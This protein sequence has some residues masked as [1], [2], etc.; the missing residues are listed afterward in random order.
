MNC[1]TASNSTASQGFDISGSANLTA[2]GAYVVSNT[3]YTGNAT[4]VSIPQINTSQS[5]TAD[6]YASRSIPSYGG[7]DKT[8]Y[9]PGASTT[10]SPN[11]GGIYVLC[12]GLTINAGVT[13]NL[14]PGTYIIDGGVLKITGGGGLIG[15]NVTL[16]LTG[17]T[18]GQSCCA[19]TNVS[20]G[21]VVQLTA[22][23]TGALSGL[24]IFQ[25][26]NAPSGTGSTMTGGDT[27]LISGA[28]YFPNTTLTYTGNS[29]ASATG[30][31]TQLI[32]DK[33]QFSGNAKVGLQ[34]GGVGVTGIGGSVTKMAE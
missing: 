32:A 16:I 23:T 18:N 10:L 27:Q 5:A 34:C 15:S 26:R 33:V 28:L 7:C 9:A 19:T 21:T 30:K 4:T 11:S 8:S 1:A 2:S 31:C 6:P 14:N 12:N 22:P 3:Y 13:V 29:T 25:D 17:G 20:G 24:A